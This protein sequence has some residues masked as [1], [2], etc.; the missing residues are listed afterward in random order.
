MNVS[1]ISLDNRHWWLEQRDNHRSTINARGWLS[2]GNNA[3]FSG[4]VQEGWHSLALAFAEQSLTAYV[5]GVAVAVG[6]PITSA[7]NGVA[8]IGSGRHRAYFDALR[9]EPVTV[10]L[11]AQPPHHHRRPL[12][13]GG[14]LYTDTDTDTDTSGGGVRAATAGSEGLTAGS[15]VLDIAPMGDLCQGCHHPI[16]YNKPPASGP[17]APILHRDGGWAGM[18]L[19]LSQNNRSVYIVRLGRY[20]VPGNNQTHS[21]QI[22]D[23]QKGAFMLT[24]AAVAQATVSLS[25]AECSPDALGFCYSEPL[26]T[27]VTLEA[28]KR[29][30]VVSEEHSGAGADAYAEM[31]DSATSTNFNVR[32]GRT[33]MSYQRPCC[34]VVSG[35]VRRAPQA[36]SWTKSEAPGHDLDTSF[37]PVNFVIK[38]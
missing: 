28:G 2:A 4:G 3:D 16:P 21:M 11:A 1:I 24:G 17:T 8:G 18:I 20:R 34:G 37:G 31:S 38:S 36:T 26:S 13:T 29:Y 32:D 30:Y 23:E 25:A 9:L 14:E 19:D 15:F 5:D 22:W 27:P 7:W 33:Y 10:P 6:V 35:R 12:A